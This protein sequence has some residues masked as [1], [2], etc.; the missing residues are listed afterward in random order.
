MVEHR[1]DAAPVADVASGRPHPALAAHLHGYLG[2]RM[3]GFAAGIHR[4]LPSSNLSVH[5]SLAEPIEL[6]GMP[7]AAQSPGR[8]DAPVGGLHVGPATIAHDGTQVGVSFELTPLGSR[9]LLGVPA[10]ALASLVVDLVDLFGP[11]A[12]ELRERMAGAPSWA[13][14]FAEL[15]DV[16]R[17]RLVEVTGP[18]P[19]VAR[20][21]VVLE[22]SGGGATVEALARH[23][24]WSRRHLGAR[25]KEETGLSPKAMARVIRFGRSRQRLAAGGTTIAA[26]AAE[27]G[28][29]DQPHL[30]REWQAMAG[31]SPSAWLAEE[32]LPSV[33]AGDP[34]DG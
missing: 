9:A 6:V 26:V 22:A 1:T 27:C 29:Y 17:R 3:E 2:Y 19:E 34:L 18:P 31:C 33:Q 32:E 20:A 24:G 15:D 21:L 11:D 25:F 16:L 13:A 7:T 30:V 10:G 4:G 23:V 8:F 14:C 28:Y 5:L 12:D